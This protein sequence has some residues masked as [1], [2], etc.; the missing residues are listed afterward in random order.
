MLEMLIFS[1]QLVLI[2]VAPF[3]E[4]VEIFT[5]TA[6]ALAFWHPSPVPKYRCGCGIGCG[7]R[8]CMGADFLVV[9]CFAQARRCKMR[10]PSLN[11]STLE[12][13]A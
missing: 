13:H 9:F 6:G 4:L 3:E 1:R 5:I 12:R 11:N 8:F 10:K 7:L 2:F